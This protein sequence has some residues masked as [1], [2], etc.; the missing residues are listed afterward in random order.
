MGRQRPRP[1]TGTASQESGLRSLESSL[2]EPETFGPAQRKRARA[3][4]RGNQ[5]EEDSCGDYTGYSQKI[6]STACG[7]SRIPQPA[8]GRITRGRPRIHFRASR[9]PATAL[10]PP[11]LRH[12]DGVGRVS[13]PRQGA[14]P[15]R[16]RGTRVRR[17]RGPDGLLPEERLP[18]DPP[19]PPSVRGRH[20]DAAARPV[21][22]YRFLRS[23]SIRRT[24]QGL[25]GARA[26]GRSG[27]PAVPA[28]G[29]QRPPARPAQVRV[30][31]SNPGAGFVRRRGDGGAQPV[32]S[33]SAGAGRPRV[34]GR[35]R[36]SRGSACGR[37][38]PQ[39]GHPRRADAAARRAGLHFVVE[40]V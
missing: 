30:G 34:R 15:G 13:R 24:C 22:G 23:R 3:R 4:A 39:P 25:P 7:T 21:A 17:V 26:H 20:A 10:P 1:G 14:L 8:A 11:S 33:R 35:S 19:V 18:P 40:P 6:N 16:F 37:P 9:C 28:R 31:T 36:A 27:H 2:R 12:L 5:Y 29:G 32:L 38:A